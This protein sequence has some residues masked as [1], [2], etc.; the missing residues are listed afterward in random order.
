M[1][2]GSGVIPV[3]ILTMRWGGLDERAL[4]LDA[5][6]PAFFLALLVTELRVPARRLP[7]LVGGLVALALVPV[8][9]VGVPVLAASAGAL[10]GLRR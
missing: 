7:A 9:P 8:A 5:V 4:G 3:L 2:V 10:L 1:Q 6:F